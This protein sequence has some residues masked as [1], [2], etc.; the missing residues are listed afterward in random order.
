MSYWRA[1]NNSQEKNQNQPT[2]WVDVDMNKEP[3]EKHSQD[4]TVT[5]QTKHIKRQ[6][7]AD[8]AKLNRPQPYTENYR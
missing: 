5:T 2:F 3:M 7:T 6:V 8:K 1:V 4:K